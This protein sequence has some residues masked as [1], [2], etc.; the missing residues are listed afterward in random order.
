LRQKPKSAK[1]DQAVIHGVIEHIVYHNPDN[2]YTVAKL[3]PGAGKRAVTITGRLAG[4]SAG[5]RVRAKGRWKIHPKY[6]QQFDIVSAESIMPSDMDGVRMFFSSG[7]IRGI[8]PDSADRIIGHFGEQIIDIIENAPGRLTE[9]KGIGSSKAAAIAEKWR[10]FRTVNGIMNFLQEN[11]VNSAYAAK[12]FS[13]YGEDAIDILCKHPYRLAEDMGTAG[14]SIAD[15]V[16]RRNGMDDNS[17][18]RISACIGYVMD[19]AG[20]EGHVFVPEDELLEETCR[21]FETGPETVRPVLEEMI[22]EHRLIADHAVSEHMTAIYPE[23]LF[24]AETGIAER[25][26]AMAAIPLRPRKGGPEAIVKHLKEKEAIS[27]S[28]EQESALHLVFSHRVCVITGGPGTGKTFLIRLVAKAF[29]D[30]GMSVCLAAPTGRAARRVSEVTSFPAHTIHRLLGFKFD[31]KCFE[32]APENPIDADVV[33]IDEASMIDTGLM[34][35]L[36]S[37]VPVTSR[38]I[39][40]G[41]A[42]QLPPVGPG[43]VLSD[44]IASGIV[45]I[46]RLH[47]IFRQAEKSEII[48]S[49]HRIRE[50]KTPEIVPFEPGFL[51]DFAF[52]AAASPEQAASII[53]D[54][55]SRILPETWGL[56]PK[57]E[58]QVLSP[59]HKGIA[60]TIDLNMR[61]QAAINPGGQCIN[62]IYH[63]FKTNDRVMHIRNNYQKEVFNGDT[64]IVSSIDQKSGKVVVSYDG[65]MVDYGPDELDE[66]TLGYAI[67]VHKSQ[68]SEYPAVILPMITRHYIMLQRNLLYTAVTRAKRLVILVGSEKAIRIALENDKPQYRFTALAQRLAG[69]AENT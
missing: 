34:Y 46:A 29:S 6:G 61:L 56:D 36:V 45:P 67:S 65:R 64:G 40:M 48:S 19:L 23:H 33:I 60:G 25:I 43:N 52:V 68:G 41:D 55:C 66:L 50:G 13:L 11:G 7:V 39:L 21:R 37:A 30:M 63:A 24:R 51:S 26:R 32:K 12:I 9:I 1:K 17:P 16:A 3:K 62:G 20:A 4:V 69:M 22:G 27:L 57:K 14:F 28:D 47:T 53:V 2:G 35:H 18:V 10:F 49:A 59:V 15:A 31:D 44:I 38:L 54:L 8:G 5:W 58:I 42:A